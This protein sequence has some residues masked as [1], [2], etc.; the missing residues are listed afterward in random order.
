MLVAFTFRA[1]PGKEKEFEALLNNPESGRAFAKMMG[2]TRN[3]LFLKEGRM[4]RVVEFPEGAKPV[5]MA[6]IMERDPK[7]KEFFRK[8]GA[9]VEGGFDPDR[10]ETLEAFNKRITYPIAYDIRA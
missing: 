7:V 3:T 10:P 9:I 1:K 8:M 6:E 4:I 5:P 2:A